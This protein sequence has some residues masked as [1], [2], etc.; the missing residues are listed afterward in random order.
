MDVKKAVEGYLIEISASHA[1]TTVK[2]YTSLL[3]RFSEYFQGDIADIHHQ[4]LLKYLAWLRNEYKP[5]RPSGLTH[6]LSGAALDNHWKCLRSFFGWCGEVLEIP[7]PDKNMPRPKFENPII[8]P[9][10]QD[11]IKRMLARSGKLRD[12][13]QAIILTLLDTGVRISELCR[14]RI[15]DVDQVKG[16]ILITPF[17]TG[18]KTKTR[19]VFLG[20]AARRAV[21]KYIA[22]LDDPHHTDKL[23]PYQS[24]QI[25]RML[26][27]IGR[28]AGVSNVHPH[29]FRHTFAI[30][31]LRNGGDI[32]TLQRLL[33]HS[34]LEMVKH[35]LAIADTD[36]QA[37]HKRA[38]PVDRWR[39]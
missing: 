28:R 30:E 15:E 17:S 23:Y 1:E 32:F 27:D 21:W 25:R 38:S 4:D 8:T 19:Y 37:A 12:R 5:V 6:P 31:Y 10:S 3:Q 14:I 36:S 34:S 24:N 39:L 33:G 20:N 26:F 29:R 7:R 13:N 22:S 11:E 18:Q 2:V 16:E 35:Y 9:F